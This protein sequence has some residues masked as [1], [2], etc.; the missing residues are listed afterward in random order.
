VSLEVLMMHSAVLR[1]LGRWLNRGG[2]EQLYTTAV[3]L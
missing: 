2:W 1:K 3:V